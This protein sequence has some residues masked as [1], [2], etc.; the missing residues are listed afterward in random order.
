MFTTLHKLSFVYATI[1][2]QT[3]I[4]REIIISA[5]IRATTVGRSGIYSAIGGDSD[6]D[7]A[8]L[9]RKLHDLQIHAPRRHGYGGIRPWLVRST[10]LWHEDWEPNKPI[11]MVIMAGRAAA[12][13]VWRG[14]SSRSSRKKTCRACRSCR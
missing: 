9:G 11:E 6:D 4:L 2:M 5:G 13:T 3:A 8:V 10:R 1:N 12:P 14:C 7:Q